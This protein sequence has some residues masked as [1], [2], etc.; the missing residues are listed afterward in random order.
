MFDETLPDSI[1]I[2][3]LR[4]NEQKVKKLNKTPKANEKMFREHERWAFLIHLLFTN[5]LLDAGKLQPYNYISIN[6]PLLLLLLHFF[7]KM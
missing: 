7:V 2:S 6:E 1:I 5:L 3:K 4:K